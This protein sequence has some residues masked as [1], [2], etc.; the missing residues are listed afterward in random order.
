MLEKK[1]HFKPGSVIT[2]FAM[3]ISYVPAFWL[4][5]NGLGQYS[6]IA[7]ALSVVLLQ[8]AGFWVYVWRRMQLVFALKWRFDRVLATK[9][10]RFGATTGLGGFLIGTTSQVDNFLLGTLG[11]ATALGYYDRAYR[12]A[13]WPSLLLECADGASHAAHLHQSAG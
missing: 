5:L 7:Q 4:A 10:M 6:L 3:P 9:M 12:M 2:S 11:G 1:L 8:E 13:Q